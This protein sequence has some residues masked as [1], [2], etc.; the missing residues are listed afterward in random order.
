MWNISKKTYDRPGVSDL[1]NHRGRLITSVIAQ[2]EE[3]SP[4]GMAFYKWYLHWT[5]EKHD[6]TKAAVCKA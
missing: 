1:F 5:N 4:K 2:D 3:V 6:L